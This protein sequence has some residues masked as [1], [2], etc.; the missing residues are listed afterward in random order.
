MINLMKIIKLYIAYF[1]PYLKIIYSYERFN[2]L[3]KRINQNWKLTK[4]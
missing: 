3:K 4:N 1:Q 2:K